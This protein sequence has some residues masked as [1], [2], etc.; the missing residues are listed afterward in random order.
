MVPRPEKA[1]QNQIETPGIARRQDGVGHGRKVKQLAQPLPQTQLH[2]AR[3]LGRAVDGPVHR[4]PHLLQVSGHL[5]EHLGRFGKGCGGVVQIDCLHR[6]SSSC[7]FL[8]CNT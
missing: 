4:G 5:P 8:Q 6:G 2:H 3:C 7:D 1:R